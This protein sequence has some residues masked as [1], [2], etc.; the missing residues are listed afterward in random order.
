[1]NSWLFCIAIVLGNTKRPA[2]PVYGVSQRVKRIGLRFH[3]KRVV[4]E[5]DYAEPCDTVIIAAGC[6]FS[7]ERYTNLTGVHKLGE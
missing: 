4:L 7:A 5:G 3:K 2:L 1:L 6:L